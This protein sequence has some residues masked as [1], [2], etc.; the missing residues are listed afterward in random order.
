M[1]PRVF[2]LGYPGPLGGANTECWHTLRLWRE[3]GL[4]V[5]VIPT[6]EA[7]PPDPRLAA[8]GVDVRQVEAGGIGM[9]SPPGLA[10][11]VVVSLCNERGLACLPRL[12]ELGCRFV[13]VN[14]MTFL[15]E[16]ER[17]T[18]QERLP[19]A[20]VFQSRFQRQ[21]LEARLD[22]LDVG[23][24]S[25]RGH[26]IP[27]AFYPDEI[28]Y[29]PRPHHLGGPFVIGRLARSDPSKW[30][31]DH[32]PI[33][34]R[35]PY[36]GRQSLNMGMGPSVL[37]KCGQP[38]PWAEVLQPNEVPVADFLGRCHA[39][40]GLNGGARENWPRIGLEAMAAGVPLV[41][42]DQW[43]WREMVLHGRTG[44]RAHQP[45]EMAYFLARLAYDEPLRANMAEAARAHVARLSDPADLWP[46]W[47][48]LFDS[49]S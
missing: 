39:L 42:E 26:L 20:F 17:Q 5:T 29:S 27:G 30:S 14:C 34:E 37:E 21:F 3:A 12:A 15:F 8:I 36:A 7:W 9:D 2:L 41:V 23:Y 1:T 49:L 25:G 35:V 45:E 44:Y 6:W 40:L 10:G 16:H 4:P 32:W 11:S 28:A 33:L 31:A 43:G 18:F 48:T 46:R 47:Q 19:D 24:S 13:W 38:P 22:R